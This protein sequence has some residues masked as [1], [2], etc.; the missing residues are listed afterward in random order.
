M[1][2]FKGASYFANQFKFTNG[3]VRAGCNVLNFSDRDI[4]RAS[5]IFRNRKAGAAGANKK[6]LELAQAFQPDI[7]MFGHAD[8][9]APETLDRLRDL[10]PGVR[11]IQWNVDPLFEPDNVDRINTK[12]DRVDLTFV[13]TSGAELE[14]LGQ[15]RYPV[16]FVPN[17]VDPGIERSRNFEK[18]RSELL[19][20]L[21]YAVGRDSLRRF[22]AGK[23]QEAGDIVRS[24]IAACPDVRGLFPGY[25]GAPLV[26][27][28]DYEL[29]LAT[30]AMGLN[31][32]RRN[33]SHLYSS[34]RIAH[35]FGSGILTFLDRA[36]GYTSLFDEDELAFYTTQDEMHE[37]ILHFAHDDQLRQTTA[38][39]GWAAYSSLFDT[40]RVARYML[41]VI[42]GSIDASTH[43]WTR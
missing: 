36:T 39:K 14:A 21:F 29:V 12:I 10:C 33:D 40:T 25:Q 28:Y 4:A 2:K 17:P 31:I 20:D 41:G 42:D 5:S 37:K 13:T 6:L 15:G 32:S 9:I 11:L 23:E 8:T 30:S 27:G 35:L 43:V 16:A 22:H 34:D 1:T 18:V 38:R 26:F 7:I 3:L 19:H 24:V